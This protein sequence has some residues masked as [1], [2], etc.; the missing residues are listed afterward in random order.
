M[1]HPARFTRDT[2]FPDAPVVDDAFTGLQWQGC[3][4]GQTGDACEFGDADASDWASALAYCEALS[5][6]GID[7]W[8]LPNRNEGMSIVDVRHFAPQIDTTTFP[9]TPSGIFW[10]S[11]S[12]EGVTSLAVGTDVGLYALGYF[13]TI[14]DKS[15]NTEYTR[16]VR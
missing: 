14:S 16:C 9:E 12:V 7:D 10:T 6:G 13:L 4:R 1:P 15:E 11:T 8:R 3:A 2:S 5:W